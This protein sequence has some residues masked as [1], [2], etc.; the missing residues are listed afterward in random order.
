VKYLRS[1]SFCALAL[2]FL[3]ALASAD[4]P[5]L[6]EWAQHRVQESILKPLAARPKKLFSRER[7]RPHDT[8]VRVTQTTLS[9][10]KHGREFVPFA[11]DVHF[12]GRQWLQNDIV[13][14]AYRAS[15]LLYVKGGD[16]YYP[17]S[18]LLGKS[19]E[20]LPGACEAGPAKS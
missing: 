4:E 8:R 5:T 10:D 19:A 16:A 17:A 11:V 18:I 9:R 7:P 12:G 13:G 2:S 6:S 1:L 14:C 15:G 3:P 20:P